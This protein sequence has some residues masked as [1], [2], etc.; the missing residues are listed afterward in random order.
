[1]ARQSTIGCKI[2]VSDPSR[3]LNFKILLDDKEVFFEKTT[4]SEYTFLSVIDETNNTHSIKFI[5]DGKGDDHTTMDGDKLISSA[6]IEITDISFDDNVISELL[7]SNE[8]LTT[9]THNSNGYSDEIVEKFNTSC[10][11]FNGEIEM[12]F[13]TPLYLWLL[14]IA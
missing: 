2:S 12:K 7:L 11:G 9:Y 4:Q 6:Q 13:E 10:M 8:S 14:D 1:M 5:M 3:P